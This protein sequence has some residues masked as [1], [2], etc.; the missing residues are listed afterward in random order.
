MRWNVR[1]DEDRSEE[2][3]KAGEEERKIGQARVLNLLWG[4]LESKAIKGQT[5]DYQIR[6]ALVI[7]ATVRG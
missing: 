7:D 4:K 5:V 6:V 2:C 3:V 1:I